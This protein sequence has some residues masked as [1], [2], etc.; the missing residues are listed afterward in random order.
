[1]WLLCVICP[2]R[3]SAVSCS[4]GRQL[5]R[6]RRPPLHGAWLRPVDA[7]EWDVTHV[8]PHQLAPRVTCPYCDALMWPEERTSSSAA[9]PFFSLCCNRGKVHLAPLLR[10]PDLLR[11]LFYDNTDHATHFRN[12][13]RTF[14]TVFQFTSAG[15]KFA[16]DNLPGGRGGIRPFRIRGTIHHRMTDVAPVGDRQ[17]RFAQ[18]YIYD[19]AHNLVSV[20]RLLSCTHTFSWILLVL[21]P[22]VTTFL[23]GLVSL[24]CVV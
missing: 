23:C 14:N 15:V 19:S 11:R 17:P 24:N 1:M 12:N 9:R 7:Q 6:Q 16:E 18:L 20:M 3:L 10:P 5:R 21:M 13:L 2:L 22:M 4:A 8:E